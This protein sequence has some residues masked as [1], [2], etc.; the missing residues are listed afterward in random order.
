M[1]RYVPN[2][3]IERTT[4]NEG[5]IFGIRTGTNWAARFTGLL[6][7]SRGGR[8]NFMVTKYWADSAELTIDGHKVLSAGCKDRSPSGYISL[9]A[10]YHKLVVVFADDGWKDELVLSYQGP[11]TSGRFQGVQPMKFSEAEW[12]LAEEGLDCTRACRAVNKQCH[13]GALSKVRTSADIRVFARTPAV[14][15]TVLAPVHVPMVT[16][17]AHATGPLRRGLIRGSALATQHE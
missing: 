15:L 5:T 16:L 9:A 7:V 4:Q 6:H 17:R 12:T 11:D 8:Y 10:G 14:A 1:G 2:V 13:Q 3:N